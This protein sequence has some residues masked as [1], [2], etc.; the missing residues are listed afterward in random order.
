MKKIFIAIIIIVAGFVSHAQDFASRVSEART[1]YSAGKLDDARFAMQQALQEL[2]IATGKEILKLLPAKIVDQSA[3]TGADNVSGASGFVG[4]IVH[5]DYG[6]A[7]D[8]SKVE[9]IT[10]SPLIGTLNTLMAVPMLANNADQKVI[11][12]QGYKA[13]LTK[14]TGENNAT[15][16]QI[17]MPLHSSLI[18]VDAPGKSPADITKIAEAL[19]VE[20]IAKLIQ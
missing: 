8:A 6:A 2:D 13:L 16:Y 11:R 15:N 14:T 12:I 4:V 1:A 7:P 10:N 20:K 3:N 9:I 5:R 19:P 17:Q 18:M